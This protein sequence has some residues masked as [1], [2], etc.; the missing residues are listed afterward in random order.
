M[1]SV[2]LWDLVTYTRLLYEQR[3]SAQFKSG[4]ARFVRIWSP[5]MDYCRHK[6]IFASITHDVQ[7]RIVRCYGIWVVWEI[8]R[9][10]KKTGNDWILSSFQRRRQRR[11]KQTGRTH[12]NVLMQPRMIGGWGCACLML[13]TSNWPTLADFKKSQPISNSPSLEGTWVLWSPF[14]LRRSPVT[15]AFI[16]IPHLFCQAVSIIWLYIVILNVLRVSCL[17][18]ILCVLL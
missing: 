17:L 3:R 4:I 8:E 9:S 6:R 15:F 14:L 16:R 2:W 12:V 1:S 18:V 5:Q 10:W 7:M 11:L 13:S